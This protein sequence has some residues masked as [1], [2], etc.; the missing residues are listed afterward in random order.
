M[1][2][3]ATLLNSIK[4]VDAAVQTLLEAQQLSAED[5][6]PLYRA[7]RMLLDSDRPDEAR[8]MLARG[9]KLGKNARRRRENLAKS[10]YLDLGR[11]YEVQGK[12]QE[13][14]AVYASAISAMP[15]LALFYVE[16]AG[17]LLQMRHY[18]ELGQLLAEIRA[19]DLWDVDQYDH[20]LRRYERTV[21]LR[22]SE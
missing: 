11:N 19:L 2:A 22:L 6:L 14:L 9:Q 8:A 20:F 3:K 5:V 12:F 21:E 15:R 16:T 1:Y 13:A 10:V 7:A 4:Q 18:Q 17:L